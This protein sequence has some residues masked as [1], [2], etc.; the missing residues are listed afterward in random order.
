M[1]IND[2]WVW[3][4]IHA[5]S[6]LIL[7]SLNKHGKRNIDWRQR[8]EILFIVALTLESFPLC[9]SKL[10]KLI[11]RWPAGSGTRVF[12]CNA[13]RSTDMPCRPNWVNWSV[14]SRC[15]SLQYIKVIAHLPTQ[16]ARDKVIKTVRLSRRLSNRGNLISE[17]RGY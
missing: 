5:L 10:N 7:I 12:Y 9:S 15:D 16:S 8:H 3:L 11:C 4:G 2:G 6:C 13:R 17:V 14:S 1:Y